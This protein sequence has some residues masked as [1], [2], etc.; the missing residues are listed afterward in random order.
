[1][2][3]SVLTDLAS[4]FRAWPFHPLTKPVSA[5]SRPTCLVPKAADQPISQFAGQ[6]SA[7][8][9]AAEASAVAC[10]AVRAKLAL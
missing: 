1:M 8:T 3:C 9:N 4:A 6:L 7:R 10:K 2:R 5:T